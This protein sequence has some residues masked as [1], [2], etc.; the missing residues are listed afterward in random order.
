MSNATVK[1]Y[2][3]LKARSAAELARKIRNH[4]VKSGQSYKYQIYSDSE[5]HYAWFYGEVQ[6]KI[7]DSELK[8]GTIE[9]RELI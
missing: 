3:F 6:I 9:A 8:A 7:K 5:Y 2:D 1:T 4:Q